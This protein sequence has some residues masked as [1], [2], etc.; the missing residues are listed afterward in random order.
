MSICRCRQ[1]KEEK[2]EAKEAKGSMRTLSQRD[3]APPRRQGVS[4]RHERIEVDT[5]RNCVLTSSMEVVGGMTR[6]LDRMLVWLSE[7]GKAKNRDQ[8]E[9]G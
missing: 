8:S 2:V 7:A 6:A 4:F 5:I 9:W 3:M 1:A